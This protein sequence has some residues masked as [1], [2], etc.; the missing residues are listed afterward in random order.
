MNRVEPVTLVIALIGGRRIGQLIRTAWVA[1]ETHVFHVGTAITYFV[2]SSVD[3]GYL[4]EGERISAFSFDKLRGGLSK[5]SLL[6][7]F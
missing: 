3:V 7:V 2:E 4:R 1:Q 6:D 5:A